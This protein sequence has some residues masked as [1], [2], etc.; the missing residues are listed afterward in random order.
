M[1][2]RRSVL[3]LAGAT[4]VSTL[5]MPWVSRGRAAD[6]VTMKMAHAAAES[7]PAHI[8]CLKF[9]EELDKLAPGRVDI[10]IFPNRQLGDEKQNLESTI[11]GTLESL[12]VSSV[13]IPLVTGR[14]AISAYQLP[15]LVRDY[16]HFTKMAT[17]PIAQKI[18]D[19][20]SGSDLVGL[21]TV[22]IGQRHFLSATKA[23]KSLPDF[24]GQKTRIVPIPLMK[25]IWETVGTAPIGLPYGEVYGA[26]ETKV[27]DAVEIN[28]S[29][30]VGEN[31]WE[32]GKHL[33]L[34]GHYP[35]P[36]AVLINKPFFDGLP[37]D[38]Q[39]AMRE[40]GRAAIAPTLA[41]T[42][43]Q[44]YSSR[45]LLKEKGVEIIPLENLAEMKA[46]VAPI[47]SEWAGKSELIAEFVSVA[48]AS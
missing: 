20:L 10:Q 34:T 29:S 42:A 32:V 6:V 1:T 40:A 45:D 47:V 7:H 44:D 27:I 41:Y 35:W 19:D 22:D 26:M 48:Q 3:A 8:A 11:T 36:A 5:A 25:E 28:V 43:E 12:I 39:A 38:L 4:A 46:R 23:V 31:L 9:K 37:A 2:T 17:S 30:I 21:M 16:D 24:A 14:P 15:F 18:L 33:T 13:I